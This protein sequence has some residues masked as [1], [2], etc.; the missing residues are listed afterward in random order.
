MYTV[1]ANA[2]IWWLLA[3]DSPIAMSEALV[4]GEQ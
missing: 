1:W 3:C 4:Q 2:G